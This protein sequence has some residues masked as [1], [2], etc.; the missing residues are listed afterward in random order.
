MSTKTKKTPTSKERDSVVISTPPPLL[1]IPWSATFGNDI[2]I[3]IW[4]GFKR[5]KR[6]V[7]RGLTT[8][9]LLCNF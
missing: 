7:G 5:L 9:R 2:H 6:E 3:Y 1:A 8:N 4:H